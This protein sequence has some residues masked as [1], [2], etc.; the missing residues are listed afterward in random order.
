MTP[1]TQDRATLNLLPRLNPHRHRGPRPLPLPLRLP[2]K[3]PRFGQSGSV[4]KASRMSTTRALRV[5][6]TPSPRRQ[7]PRRTPTAKP[8]TRPAGRTARSL[9][10]PAV[11]GP[12]TRTAHRAKVATWRRDLPA[13]TQPART[14]L[15]LAGPMMASGTQRPSAP[16]TQPRTALPTT[17]PSGSGQRPRLRR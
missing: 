9:H 3:L 13:T 16:R 10:H 8:F 2:C 15:P 14:P 1:L 5:V 6:I 11:T 12:I 4:Q 7:R 17:T